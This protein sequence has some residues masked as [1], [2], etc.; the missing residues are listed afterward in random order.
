MG[1][2]QA[3]PFQ[4]PL[5]AAIFAKP[6][7]Q[8]IEDDIAAQIRQPRDQ[9]AAAVRPQFDLDHVIARHPQRIRAFAPR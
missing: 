6:A 8:G 7:M 2:R 1:I 5:D 3:K 9:G 4:N